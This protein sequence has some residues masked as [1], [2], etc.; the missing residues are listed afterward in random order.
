M[1]ETRMTIGGR[2]V[3]GTASFEVRNPANGQVIGTAPNGSRDDLAAAVAA[4][5]KAFTSWSRKSDDE[6]AAACRAVT[7]KIGAHAEELARL[8]TLEQGKP[9]NGLGSRWELGG[10]AAWAGATAALSLPPRVLQDNAQGHVEIFRKPVGVVG[11][12]TPWNFPVLIAVWHVLPALRTGNTVVIKP[13]PYTPLA[14]LR[15]VE[16]LNEVLPEGV[17]NSVSCDD[18]T[19]NLGA[20]MASDPVIRKIVFTGS[21]ATGKKVMQSAASTMKRLTLELGGNDAGIVLPDADPK[22]IA[23][24]LFWGAFLNNGQTCAAM[25]RLYVHASI[26]DEVCEHLA[27]FA[28]QVPMGDGM[29]EKNVLGPVQNR[30]QFDKV[31]R[32][33]ADAKKKGQ[34]LTGGEPGE[35]LFFPATIVAGLK[36]GDALVDEEQFGPALPVIRYTDVEDAIRAANDSENGLGGSVWSKDIEHAKRIASRLECGSVWINKH[37]AIQPNAP[38]GGVKASGLG[39]EFAEEGLKEYTDAQVIFS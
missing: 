23:E 15:F 24:G 37:G 29:D 5:Q 12:I 33:V 2:A 28:K 30:M 25:K 3:P 20:D 36:N 19:S 11:S 32:L 39:V 21:C 7:E 16:L 18:R 17:V 38:F 6:L 22:A 31:A 27:A 1:Q 10:A 13:S 4:A 14:T 35:G 34:V 8:L 9:L 26:H